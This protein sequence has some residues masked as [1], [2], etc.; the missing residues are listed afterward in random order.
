MYYSKL[1]FLREPTIDDYED[2]MVVKQNIHNFRPTAT[3]LSNLLVITLFLLRMYVFK[4]AVWMSYAML[5]FASYSLTL[6]IIEK[7]LTT[8]CQKALDQLKDCH[9]FLN[10]LDDTYSDEYQF[11]LIWS[12][13][14]SVVLTLKQEIELV[15]ALQMTYLD[16]KDVHKI[17]MERVSELRNLIIQFEALQS[18][19]RN[20]LGSTDTADRLNQQAREL[21][22]FHKTSRKTFIDRID[23]TSIRIEEFM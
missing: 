6:L 22:E 4:Q 13:V 19:W 7:R 9:Q 14:E 8:L 12:P 2:L 23:Q 15:F 18:T 16:D 11:I 21:L 1:C 10:E 17:S 5:L 3:V 20:S